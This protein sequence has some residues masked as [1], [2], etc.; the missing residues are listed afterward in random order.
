MHRRQTRLSGDHY[1]CGVALVSHK[2]NVGKLGTFGVG[3]VVAGLD[4]GPM[5]ETS[6][7]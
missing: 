6:A 4:I 2:L 3:W 1:T 7:T 5:L